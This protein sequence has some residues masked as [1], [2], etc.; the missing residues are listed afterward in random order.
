[1]G[2]CAPFHSLNLMTEYSVK[3]VHAKVFCM[4]KN[5]TLIGELKY[6]NRFY[7][8]GQI[9]MADSTRYM[10]EPKGFFGNSVELKDN[11]GVL[12]RFK[13]NW[14]GRITIISFFEPYER[15]FMF[16]YKGILKAGC[17][18]TDVDNNELASILQK[19]KFKN[20]N[21]EYSITAHEMMDRIVYKEILLMICI[22]C[23]QYLRRR[24]SAAINH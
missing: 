22:N 18:L 17:V 3:P 11:R 16:K 15:S 23:T 19:F 9:V 6:N 7:N 24:D 12:M 4:T 1:M 2:K 14:I 20:F 21:Y 8:K 10:I 5:D 13:Q